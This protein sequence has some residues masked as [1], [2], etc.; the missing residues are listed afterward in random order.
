MNANR[1]RKWW[2]RERKKDA[3]MPEPKIEFMYNRKYYRAI[4][5]IARK[6]AKEE[7]VKRSDEK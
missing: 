6:E 1:I 5:R 3:A 4:K 7:R 2:N